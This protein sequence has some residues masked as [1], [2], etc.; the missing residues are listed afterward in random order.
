[1]VDRATAVSE[2]LASVRL[3]G[4]QPSREMELLMGAWAAG[5]VSDEQ[6]DAATER[7]ASG[8]RSG[9]TELLAARAA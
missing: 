9:L 2:A 5:E 8:D 7:L 6:F 1:M 4:L 3:E